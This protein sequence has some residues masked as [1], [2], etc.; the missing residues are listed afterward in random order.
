M[1]EQNKKFPEDIDVAREEEQVRDLFHQLTDTTEVPQ[2]IPQEVPQEEIPQEVL[3]EAPA[4]AE[5]FLPPILIAEDAEAEDF[6]EDDSQEEALPPLILSHYDADDEDEMPDGEDYYD[7]FVFPTG[8]EEEKENVQDAPRE[9]RNPFVAF[10]R[11]LCDNVPLPCDGLREILRKS[12]FWLAIVVLAGALTYILYNVWWLPAFTKDMYAGVKGDYHPEAI[13]TVEDSAEYPK[14]MQLSFQ[15]LYDR[16]N[17]VRGWLSYH[18]AGQQDFLNIEYPIMYSGDNEKY[19]TIDFNGN[20]NKNGALFFDERS[21][22]QSAEDTN[23]ALIVYGHNMASGQMFAG[24]NKF[25]GNVNNARV[26]P[27]LTMNTLFSNGEY[28]VFAVVMTDEIAENRYYFNVR[29]LSF[30]DEEDF[31]GYI[32][33]LRSIIPLTCRQGMSCCCCLPARWRV[34]QSS[35]TDA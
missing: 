16:N 18:A 24:L 20:K 9:K 21:K 26:A 17:E 3:Q 29:R 4:Q 13:G 1:A 22:L 10:W 8:D 14:K 32:A 2:E 27:T 11:A 25:I 30:H 5:E 15:M 6:E 12:V 23:T 7:H 35:K 31:N 19:L 34:P 33:Q 28:K